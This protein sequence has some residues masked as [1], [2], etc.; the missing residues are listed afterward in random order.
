MRV[1]KDVERAVVVG[2]FIAARPE[3]AGACLA[4]E[5]AHRHAHLR[6]VGAVH[7][8]MIGHAETDAQPGIERTFEHGTVEGLRDGIRGDEAEAFDAAFLHEL[9]RVPAPIHHEVHRLGHIAPRFA[10][11]FHVAVAEREA[12]P[13]VSDER[14]IADDEIRLRPVGG[15]RVFVGEERDARGFVGDFLAGDGMPFHRAAI[16]AGD[17]LALGR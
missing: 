12:H 3:R 11:G 10:H 14:R 7:P 6:A 2:C 9:C 1:E 8:R 13:F 15:A 16:P 4:I 5:D 17:G